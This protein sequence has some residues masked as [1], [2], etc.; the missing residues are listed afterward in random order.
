MEIKDQKK[1]QEKGPIGIITTKWRYGR[2]GKPKSAILT[3]EGEADAALLIV[4][5]G[6][7]PLPT[8]TIRHK[9]MR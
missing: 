4:P 5:D 9:K 2:D 3:V 6:Q 8:V 1:E 7:Y